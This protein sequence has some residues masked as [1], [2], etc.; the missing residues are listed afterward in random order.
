MTTE[1]TAL[2][3]VEKFDSK[4]QQIIAAM[5]KLYGANNVNELVAA[6]NA[7]NADRLYLPDEAATKLRTTADS[8]AQMRFR[9]NGPKFVKRGRRVLYRHADLVAWVDAQTRQSTG[10]AV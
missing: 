5:R 6:I 8:L 10:E 7:E 9:G 2:A 4:A 3:E 1:T